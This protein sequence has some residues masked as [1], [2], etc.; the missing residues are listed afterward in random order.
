[1]MALYRALLR[2]YPASF[3]IEYGDE[4]CAVFARRRRD[5]PGALARLALWPEAVADVLEN[6]ARAHADLF[7]QDLRYTVRT[8][9]RSPGFAATSILVAAL[10][11]G[12]TTATFSI[13]DHVLLR[14]LPFADGQ[15]LVKLWEDPSGRGSSRM[16][17]S[18]ANYR[19]WKRMSSSFEAMGAYRNLAVNLVGVGEPE[20]LQAVPVTADL[21][22][23]L[24]VQPELGRLF[25]PADDREGAPGTV[26]LSHRLWTAGF[27]GDPGVLGRKVILNDE[28]YTVIGVMPAVFNFP[29]RDAELW[30]A[31]RFREADFGSRSDTFLYAVARLGRSVSLD[32]ARA[33]MR[34]IAAQLERA[35]PKEN[36]QVGAVILPLRDE[37]SPQARQLLLALFGAALCVLLIACANLANLLLAR[38]LFRRKELAVRT[39]LGAGRERLLRQLLTESLVLA[40]CGGLLGVL[41]A[42]VATPLITRL[43]PNSLPIAGAPEIDLRVLAF[44]AITTVL[45]GVGFGVAPALRAGRDAAASG[46]R[47][48]A[49]SL[50]SGRERLRCALVSAEI[51]M[52]VVLLVS[53]GL[54]L[55]ALGRVQG[56]DPG[57][58]A[59]GVLTLRTA[60]P[61]P[62]YEKTAARQQFYTRVL[63]EVGAL[64]GVSRAAYVTGL[65]MAMRGGI[66]SVEVPG[67]AEEPPQHRTV[68]LRF[69]TPGFFAALGIPVRAG[70]DVGVADTG[71]APLVAVVSESFVR[72]YWPGEDGL[73]RRFKIASADRAIVGVVGDVRVRGLERSSEPQVYLPSPQVSDGAL[74]AYPPKDLVVRSRADPAAL[75]PAI[76]RIVA[77]ADP[78]QPISDVRM[79]ADIVEAET[80][81]RSVQVQVLGAFAAASVLLAAIGIHG[82]L[83]FTVASRSQEFGVRVALGAMAGDILALVLREGALLAGAGVLAGAALAYA[84]G[85]AMEAL[86]AGV[87]PADA[88]TFLAVGG[89][90]VIV[91]LAGSLSPALRAVR[92]DPL[93]AIRTE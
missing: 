75:L 13:T 87:S 20:R 18:P 35:F 91:T 93:T 12:A 80:A 82:L 60:L 47:E 89:L 66:W 7:R 72:K 30:T 58:R 56:T 2:A 29:T 49:R 23:M 22:P 39:A 78:Q 37:V 33:E 59:E 73:G 63:S 44:A 57:F 4:M 77:R 43:V 69:T 71:E 38:G 74:I 36:E 5:A 17:L 50:G 52:T 51:A 21:L 45:T 68:S 55:R 86:L 28:A 64:P 83:A 11:V 25:D 14:P 67:H 53:C 81:P 88:R 79:L 40:A 31:M 54:L 65:P 61:F 85:R 62:R 3:R 19:D 8:L 24:G 41:V 1:M 46:M 27:G 16:E 42:F 90:S 26:L 10:G 9:R 34:L 92:L 6:A 70:R 84:A 76:R 15:R 48:G 32:Q